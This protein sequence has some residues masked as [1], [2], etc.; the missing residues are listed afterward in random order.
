MAKKCVF[1][2]SRPIPLE[3]LMLAKYATGLLVLLVV[4]CGALIL[5]FFVRGWALDRAPGDAAAFVFIY[6]TP[7]LVFVYSVAFFLGCLVRRA[8]EAAMLSAIAA[9]LVYFAPLVVPPLARFGVINLMTEAETDALP[10][11]GLFYLFV[12]TCRPFIAVMLGGSLVALI[13]SIQAIRRDWQLRVGKKLIFWIVAGAVILLWASA[14]FPLGVN[15]TCEAQYDVPSK[16]PSEPRMVCG[17][18]ASGSQGVLLLTFDNH[19]SMSLNGPYTFSVCRFDLSQAAAA[20]GPETDVAEAYW[21]GWGPP[22]VHPIWS[23]TRPERAYVLVEKAEEVNGQRCV[24]RLQSLELHTIVFKGFEQGE[25]VSKLDLTEHLK[26]TPDPLRSTARMALVRDTLCIRL[27]NDLLVIDMGDGYTPVVSDVRQGVSGRFRVDAPRRDPDAVGRATMAML[28]IDG[29]S[30]RERLRVSLELSRKDEDVDCLDFEGDLL[31][32]ARWNELTT[33]RLTGFQGNEAN[34]QEVGCRR[35]TTLE[36]GLCVFGP[37]RVFLRD[38]LAYVLLGV[39]NIQTG[40]TVYDVRR[41]ERPRRVGH[42]VG[43]H[44]RFRALACLPGGRTLLAGRKL[45]VIAPV[46]QRLLD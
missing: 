32:A 14:A 25:V 11:P 15:L 28:P 9:A 46:P 34:F 29:L 20:F 13:L 27:G 10:V 4:T 42:Y 43:P 5:Q 31:V 16:G 44:G 21:K 17:M 26:H 37:A 39:F 18:A 38:G 30:P 8:T 7:V 36:R 19:G 41:P 12:A 6:H 22:T 35:A 23:P 33:Y 3:R 45:D 24:R 1:W 40:L 2:Q